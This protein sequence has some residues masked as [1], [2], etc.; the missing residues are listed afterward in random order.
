[1]TTLVKN[2]LPNS[3]MQSLNPF[4]CFFKNDF[5]DFWN[6]GIPE[7]IPS[8]YFSEEMDNY[9]IE[10]TAPGL[11]KDDFI[12]DVGRNLMTISCENYSF[13]RSFSIPDNGDANR[14]VAKYYDGVLDLSIPKKPK[15]K[16]NMTHKII[17]E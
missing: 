4:N 7:T 6:G 8:I 9:K 5:I 10:M 12:I 3:Q 2:P 16:K 15:A 11:E 17:V 13:S 1:M 14:I